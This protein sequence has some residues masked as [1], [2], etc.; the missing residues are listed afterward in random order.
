MLCDDNDYCM[1][2]IRFLNLG[3]EHDDIESIIMYTV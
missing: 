3:T 2:S 1:T